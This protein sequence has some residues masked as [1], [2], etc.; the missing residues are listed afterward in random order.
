MW[1][2]PDLFPLGDQ[3]ILICCPQGIAREEERFLNTYP[4]VWMA[5]I[6]LRPRR[7]QTRRA[8]RAGR[9]I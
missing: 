9:R 6:R 5:A 7:V 1:E 4:A 8:A 2:C 3:H